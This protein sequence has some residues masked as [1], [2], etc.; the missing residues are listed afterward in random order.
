M[1]EKPLSV[2]EGSGE[3]LQRWRQNTASHA[4]SSG[5][6]VHRCARSAYTKQL[7]KRR[8]KVISQTVFG[9]ASRGDHALTSNTLPST[10][11]AVHPANLTCLDPTPRSH[12]ME[13]PGLKLEP[14]HNDSMLTPP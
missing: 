8:P 6:D 14:M 12:G 9:V 3:Y 10:A 1:T 4:D 2:S 13:C 11:A 7:A 5:D